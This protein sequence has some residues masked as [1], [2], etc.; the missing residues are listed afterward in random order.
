MTPDEQWSRIR[1]QD[2]DEY[3][4]NIGNGVFSLRSAPEL[5]QMTME[6]RDIVRAH[7]LAQLEEML[8]EQQFFRPFR[9]DEPRLQ[10][11][12][13]HAED[14]EAYLV[15][16]WDGIYISFRNGRNY[17]RYGDCFS[18][19]A[20]I[21]ERKSWKIGRHQV[22]L[23]A[24]SEDHL[25]ISDRF[26]FSRAGVRLFLDET[27]PQIGQ[28]VVTS[29]HG[30]AIELEA[31]YIGALRQQRVESAALRYPSQTVRERLVE[32][33]GEKIVAEALF[34]TS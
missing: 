21:S 17:Y 12:A 30:L 10:V 18:F 27:L 24:L 29:V 32:L 5:R 28:L 4:D 25:Q 14:G 20:H 16:R 23:V 7:L 22:T 8:D 6:E 1:T 13:K 19:L 34:E 26:E 3:V 11:T 33:F 15:P 31:D 9:S 2:L